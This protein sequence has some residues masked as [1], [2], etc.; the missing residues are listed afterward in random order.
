MRYRF[1][2]CSTHGRLTE[3]EMKA[4]RNGVD[5]IVYC[6]EC[7]QKANRKFIIVCKKHGELT[8]DEIKANSKGHGVCRLCHREGAN[9]RR[10][11]NRAEFNAK[12][13]NDRKNNPEKWDKIYKKAYQ[14]KRE[15]H[16]DL[17]SLIKVCEKRK[18]KLE[19]YFQMIED[20]DNKCAICNKEETCIDGR[21]VNKKPRRLSID[22]CHV[23]GK[24]RGLLCHSCNTAIGKLKDDLELFK[25]AMDYIIKHRD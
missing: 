13:E 16:G 1:Y 5:K 23:S 22:H 10:N 25:K 9:R 18:I 6:K 11:N 24:V 21:S 20:Q 3:E 8:F 2:E 19:K 12:M 15:E 14:N 4:V 7:G 17:L